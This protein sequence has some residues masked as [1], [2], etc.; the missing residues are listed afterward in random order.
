ME[1]DFIR[2][3]SPEKLTWAKAFQ[4]ITGIVERYGGT[5]E[6]DIPN[7]SFK[8]DVPEEHTEACAFEVV[9]VME[10]LGLVEE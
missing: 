6:F 9:E 7:Y 2:A 10:Q 8:I 1:D 3:T 5:V 4:M